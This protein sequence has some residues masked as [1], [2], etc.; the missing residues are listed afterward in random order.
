MRKT[1]PA[2]GLLKFGNTKE[3]RKDTIW[4]RKRSLLI[5]N[6][7]SGDDKALMMMQP[8]NFIDASEFCVR[9]FMFYTD[10]DECSDGT[11]NCHIE[12]SCTN[13]AGGF[14]CTCNSGYSGD[15]VTCSGQYILI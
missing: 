2:T 6:Q 7:P 3:E 12:A 14:D 8:I 5:H 15:G 1:E 4:K 13:N 11:D 10:V 9:F